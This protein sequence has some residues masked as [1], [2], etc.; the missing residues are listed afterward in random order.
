MRSFW[1]KGVILFLFVSGLFAQSEA[2][3]IFL[4][5]SPGARAGGMGESGVA[6][7]DDAYA[8]YW[9]PAGL[10][11]QKGTEL[12]MMHVNW[13]PNLASDLYYDFFTMRNEVPNLGTIGG[14]LIFLSLGQQQRTDEIG[15]DLGTF[16]SYM[17]AVTGSYGTLLSRNSSIGLNVKISH[18]HLADQGAGA[19]KGHGTST[20]LGFDLG[21]LQKNFIGQFMD[22]GLTITNI[23]PKVSFIDPAQG[24]PQPTNLTLG[25]NFKLLQSK[26][27]KMNFSWD[28][29]KL[30]VSKYPNMDWD[31]NGVIGGYDKY[32]H[33]SDSNADYNKNGQ[34]EKGHSDPVYLAIFTSWVNDWL[35]GG[36]VDLDS[37]R[38]I[39]GFY[40]DGT[41]TPDS[42]PF[43]DSNYGV[44]N[45]GGDV[46]VGT[47]KD[48]TIN[49]ELNTLIHH[50]GIEYWYSGYFALRAGYLYDFQG[51]ISNQTYGIGLRFAGYGFDFGYISG[52]PGHPL[53]NTMRFSLGWQF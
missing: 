2:G 13:L 40:K 8:T 33:I 38:I 6:I 16:Y 28:I 3:D 39:G 37:D 32:G 45:S 14:H 48:R 9:N 22:L 34:E 19:E 25:M 30:L 4:L 51:K 44:Y 21:Y 5:I 15:T 31:G 50:V 12:G 26:Y 17:L 11:F 52:P 23:G 47:G 35:L 20:V 18:Q 36:D 41:A 10:G 1:T 46:E 53:T 7:A 27:N 42:I 43:G 29:Q 49:N 24:D